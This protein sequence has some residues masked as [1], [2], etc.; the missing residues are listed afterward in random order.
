M[1]CTGYQFF[2]PEEVVSQTEHLETREHKFQ[3]H[4]YQ[5]G[6]R[7]DDYILTV[8]SFSEIPTLEA[9]YA[10]DSTTLGG[11][12]LLRSSGPF[13]FP[14]TAYVIDYNSVTKQ[15]LQHDVFDAFST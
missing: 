15:T 11:V 6:K 9:K 4:P 2:T 13:I 1:L 7:F 12:L 14:N 5:P 3:M 8:G 10:M